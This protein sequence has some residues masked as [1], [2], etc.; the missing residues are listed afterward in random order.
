MPGA[1]K[2]GKRGVAPAGAPNFARVAPGI[3]LTTAG[4]KTFPRFLFAALMFP[5]APAVHAAELDEL[6]WMVGTWKADFGGETTASWMANRSFLRVVTKISTDNGG[7]EVT[8]I[9]GFDPIKKTLRSWTFDSMS[10]VAEGVMT[11][12]GNRWTTRSAFTSR[13]GRKGSAKNTLT[14]AGDDML[15]WSSVERDLGGEDLPDIDAVEFKRTGKA[16]P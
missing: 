14:K 2:P 7:F 8:E 12:E 3:A 9:I 1:G 6:A 5:L 4:M 13:D 16:Q 11:R 10:G 15:T